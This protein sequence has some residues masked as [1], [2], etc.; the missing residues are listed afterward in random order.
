M[1]QTDHFHAAAAH[2]RAGRVPYPAALIARVAEFAGLGAEHRVLDLGCGPGPLALAFAPRA[3]EVVALDPSAAMLA[4]ARA[5]AAGLANIRFLQS[6]STQLATLDGPFR[7][8]TMGRSFHW[9]D[10]P[11]TLAALE[12]LVDPAGLIA[13]FDDA[14]P[15]L[16]VNAWRKTWQAIRCRHF[17][18]EDM[19][20]HRSGWVRH[21]GVLLESAFCRLE[22]HGVLVRRAV[23]AAA[24]IERALS[25]STTST[26][27]AEAD[28]M[29]AEMRG[30]LTGVRE[31]VVESVALLAWRKSR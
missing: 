1:P 7:L 31:E 2:Y 5:A 29:V 26:P 16:P 6:D 3:G 20:H 14:W 8:V 4:E 22:R 28:A 18:G 12:R 11:A 10:R 15:D 9:M 30:E 24:L 19:L 27:G 23:D 17:P 13:L 21:E 25:M